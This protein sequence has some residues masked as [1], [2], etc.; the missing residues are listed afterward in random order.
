MPVHRRERV[1]A[2]LHWDKGLGVTE[3][4][5]TVVIALQEGGAKR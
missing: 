1:Y 5:S 2:D 3:R 4:V